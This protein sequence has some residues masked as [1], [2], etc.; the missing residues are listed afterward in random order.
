MTGSES[1]REPKEG[2]EP[3]E[4]A[5]PAGAPVTGTITGLIPPEW[6]P[7][8]LQYLAADLYLPICASSTLDRIDA[9][10]AWRFRGSLAQ[11]WRTNCHGLGHGQRFQS[12]A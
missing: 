3:A 1:P 7:R 4:P 6:F 9:Q 10:M 12:A 5:R 8:G 2:A 11:A